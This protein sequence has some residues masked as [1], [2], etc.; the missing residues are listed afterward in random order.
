MPTKLPE[1]LGDLPLDDPRL[2]TD[3]CRLIPGT[4]T[5]SDVLLVGVVHD[6][7]ASSYRVGAIADAFDPDI[8]GLELPPL[9][10][11][12]FERAAFTDDDSFDGGEMSAAIA[13]APDATVTGIDSL[14]FRFGR[15]FLSNARERDASLGTIRTALGEVGRITRHAI[16]CRL[17]TASAHTAATVDHTASAGHSPVQQA[18]DER[19]QVARSRSLLGAIERPR[20]DLLVDATREETMA[21]AIARKRQ[22]GSV[23][24]VVGMNHLGALTEE[25]DTPQ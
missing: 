8:L 10:V 7:P 22:S 12:A 5:T 3:F 13:A 9:A 4:E 18:E 15:C 17:N 1:A 25:L 23:L 11:P 20:A 2:D 6:H 16:A 24:A 19:T 14:G 21:A